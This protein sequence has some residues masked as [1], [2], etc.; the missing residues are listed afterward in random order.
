MEA[1]VYTETGEHVYSYMFLRLSVSGLKVYSVIGPDRWGD[2]DYQNVLRNL[3]A[4][5]DT[6]F[7]LHIDYE[8]IEDAYDE[9]HFVESIENIMQELHLTGKKMVILFDFGDV[10]KK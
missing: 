4:P 3:T 9:E 6:L 7:C 5:D 8:T 1:N 10:T 2:I